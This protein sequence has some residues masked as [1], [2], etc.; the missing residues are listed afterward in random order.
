MS[1]TTTDNPISLS[2]QQTL[3]DYKLHIS[4]DS[5]LNANQSALEPANVHDNITQTSN[6]HNW[7]RHHNRIPNYRPINRNLDMVDRPNGRNGAEVMF[8]AIMFTGVAMNAVSLP[9]RTLGGFYVRKHMKF[10]CMRE[11]DSS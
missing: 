2:I 9:L 10:V 4:G 6:P 1:A 8:I 11:A 3:V 5:G 7:P